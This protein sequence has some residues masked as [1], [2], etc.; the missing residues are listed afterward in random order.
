[1]FK[2]ALRLFAFTHLLTFSFL[3]PADD[4]QP[5][6]LTMESAPMVKI[7]NAKQPFPGVLVG[8]Q[9]TQT[10]LAELKSKGYKT[11]INLRMPDELTAWNE[12]TEVQKLN[13]NYVAI[14]VGSAESINRDNSQRLISVL[15]DQANYPVLVHCASGNRVGALFALDAFYNKKLNIEE[16]LQ[17]GRESGLT[18]LE[19]LVSYKLNQSETNPSN[20][21]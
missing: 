20:A 14:P 19:Q 15:N 4:Y 3:A 11:I 16:A 17:V 5:S 18:K 9:P 13:M 2:K 1:M 21:N 8:G 12:S 7:Y 6:T 10:E